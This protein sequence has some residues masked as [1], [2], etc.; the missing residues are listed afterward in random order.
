MLDCSVIDGGVALLVH[1][2]VDLRVLKARAQAVM[3]ELGDERPL[4]LMGGMTGGSADDGR[5]S[6]SSLGAFAVAVLC[7]LA[8]MPTAAPTGPRPPFSGPLAAVSADTLTPELARPRLLSA[9]SRR[10]SVGARVS[11]GAGSAAP[12]AANAS[13]GPGPVPEVSSAEGHRHAGGRGRAGVPS[14]PTAPLPSRPPATGAVVDAVSLVR[15]PQVSSIELFRGPGQ[16]GLHH[17][18]PK[19]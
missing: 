9:A 8:L 13:A 3:F 16:S 1:P 14:R 5:R 17:H 6:P 7:L 2:E 15:L 12:A 4:L 19:P 11:A 10:A 18:G